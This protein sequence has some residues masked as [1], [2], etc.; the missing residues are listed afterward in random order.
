M[1]LLTKEIRKKIP[2]LYS[3]ENVALG[4][5]EIAVKFF[6]PVGAATWYATEGEPQYDEDG[7]EVD[8]LFFGY[9]D[10]FG[11]DVSGEFGYFTL[12]QLEE[13][14]LPF[15]LGIERDMYFG[16]KKIKD[17]VKKYNEAA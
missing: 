2:A 14:E 9:A 4:E 11:D 1:K 10:L 7:N 3:N 13:V 16:K 8:F 17:V 5:Q 15:G 6:S 12:K